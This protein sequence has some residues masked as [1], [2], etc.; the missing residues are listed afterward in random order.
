MRTGPRRGHGRRYVQ[1][2]RIR[3]DDGERVSIE[4]RLE[5]VLDGIRTRGRVGQCGA[6]GP[7]DADVRPAQGFE[8]GN[9][10]PAGRPEASDE[11]L[12][13]VAGV[14]THASVSA[15]G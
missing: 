12:T 10:T 13:I 14:E 5:I 9:V 1:C 7:I 3:H 8:I 15:D 6:S 11:D 2:S 4:R